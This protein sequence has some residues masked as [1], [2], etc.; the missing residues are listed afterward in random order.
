MSEDYIFNRDQKKEEERSIASDFSGSLEEGMLAKEKIETLGNS[1]GLT[2][3]SFGV[4]VHNRIMDRD[5]AGVGFSTTEILN[6]SSG[7]SPLRPSGEIYSINKKSVSLVEDFS[8]TEG[9]ET[10]RNS[11]GLTPLDFDIDERRDSPQRT[12]RT[13][14]PVITNFT[15][16]GE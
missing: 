11:S 2:P 14:S 16:K 5:S 10:L 3:L 8:V 1:S 15:Y 13:K 12:L 9:L 4:N 6:N 7:L